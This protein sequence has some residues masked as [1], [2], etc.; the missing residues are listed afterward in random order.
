MIGVAPFTATGSGN[1]D[2]SSALAMADIK[3]MAK[4]H[5]PISR[6]LLLPEGLFTGLSWPWKLDN[7]SEMTNGHGL[8][9]EG[10]SSV[11]WGHLDLT[12]AASRRPPTPKGMRHF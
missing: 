11:R 1:L 7:G 2:K 5:I 6:I 8:A 9:F 12:S 3:A 4:R 10:S